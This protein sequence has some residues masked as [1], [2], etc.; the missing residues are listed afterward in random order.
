[1]NIYHEHNVER[2]MN[3]K[4][5]FVE[6]SEGNEKHI[7]G[8]CRKGNP[9]FKVAKTWLN[10]SSAG[11]KVGLVRDEPGYLDLA[12]KIFKQRMQGTTL[13]LLAANVKCKMKERNCGVN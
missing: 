5:V 13:V 9:C 10:Y 1:M 12:E 3:V 2:Y 7:I 4:D 6:V 11:C 8:H